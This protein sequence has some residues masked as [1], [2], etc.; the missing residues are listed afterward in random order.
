MENGEHTGKLPADFHSSRPE[1]Q[2]FPL[3]V[4]RDHV[5]Q[6]SRTEKYLHQLEVKGKG[7]LWKEY[8][9]RDGSSDEDE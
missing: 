5:Y 8:R 9:D 7:A 3:K 4:F 6:I 1:Y 2:L